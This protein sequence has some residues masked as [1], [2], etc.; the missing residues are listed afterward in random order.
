MREG[1]DRAGVVTGLLDALAGAVACTT[2]RE[3]E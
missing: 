3:R 2:R 1:G